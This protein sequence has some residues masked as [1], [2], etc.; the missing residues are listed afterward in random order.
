MSWQYHP[1]LVL[2]ALGGFVSLGVAAYC[3]QYLRTNGRSVLVVSIGLL[4]VNNAV[5][6]FA[7]LLK[8]ASPTV[9]GSLLF[10]KLQFVGA[11]LNP[12]LGVVIALA[13]TGRQRWL[14]RPLIGGIV[15]GS[16]LVL[17]LFLSNPNSAVIVNPTMV[18]AQGI[19][20]F[21]HAFTPVTVIALGW[22]YALV[23]FTVSMLG[24]GVVVEETPAVPAGIMALTFGLPLV[25][26]LLKIGGIYPP[27][28]SGI[29]PTPAASSVTIA[30]LAVA[31]SRY[32]L[33]DLVPVGREQAIAEMDSGYLLYGPDRTILDT[34][35]SARELLGDSPEATLTGRPVTE[36]LPVLDELE[37]VGVKTFLIDDRMIEA[38]AST[39]TRQHHHDAWMVLLRDVSDRE[40]RKRELER[41]NQR[42]ESLI[43][44]APLTVM[45]INA[46]G[47]VLRWNQEAEEMFGW[48]ADEVVGEY[49]PMVPEADIAEFDINRQQVLNGERIRGKEIQRTTKDGRTL[50]LLLAA[51]PIT[52]PDGEVRSIIAVLDDITDQKRTESGLRSLQKTA[53]R[54]SETETQT[55]ICAE[56][57]ASAV[58]VL[59]FDLTGLWMVEGDRLVPAKLTDAAA[60]R[61]AEPPVLSRT[62][63]SVQQAFEYGDVHVWEP[64]ETDQPVYGDS[65]DL[66]AVITVPV[67]EYGLLAI[68]TPSE[69]TVSEREIE[70]LRILGSTTQAALTRADREADLRRQNERLDEFASVVAHDLRNPL[71]IAEGFLDLAAE[72]DDPA[73][74]EKV[75]SAHDRALRLIDDLLTLARG[76]STVDDPDQIELDA[77][78][79]EAWEYVDSA[80]ATLSIGDD[81][82]VLA[83]DEGRLT[84]L[85]ENL[86][87]NA[88]EHGGD[89]VTI[90]I[91][92]LTDG[93]G[94]YVA[95][96]GEGIPP[97]RREEVLEHGVSTSHQGTGFGLS[98]VADIARAHGWTVSVTDSASGG[99]KFEFSDAAVDAYPDADD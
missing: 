89:D 48:R 74:F 8:T 38:Q 1:F 30:A 24:Y 99:A 52:D 6:V 42:L 25:F 32:R 66:N 93:H 95:D 61:F 84:Q 41:T 26:A 44:S 31:V 45:E 46:D 12:A 39:V 49:N 53:Q 4:A 54:L 73:H 77:V 80:E 68:A 69:A 40:E 19:M 16:T 79:A 18:P 14:T 83:G 10:Y 85:F 90:T 33:F 28:G 35:A 67:G 47:E 43:D 17:G 11:A 15:G 36:C 60:A 75:R 62:D 70:L 76:D 3:W 37:T 22:L 58:E 34:N 65:S 9:G 87:R 51:A 13:Y 20:A 50:D 92:A 98:I 27:N 57:V 81:L 56:T 96:D 86:Y 59:G 64:A 88:V 78:A 82:P 72:S 71:S 21:E 94:F 23:L 2:F 29:N 97:D 63:E 7:A 91:G 5:W 55:D